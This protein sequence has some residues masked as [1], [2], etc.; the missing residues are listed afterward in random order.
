MSGGVF[1]VACC[2]AAPAIAQSSASFRLSEHTFNA[3]GNPTQGVAPSSV[4]FRI[5]L[6]A[7]GQTTPAR[8]LSSASFRS[9][10]GFLPAFAPPGE[11]EGVGFL[12]D[13]ATF[14]W[15]PD[16]SVGD[17]AVYRDGLA[18]LPGLAYGTCL[19][20]AIATASAADPSAPADGQGFFYLVTA[21]NRLREEGTKGFRSGGVERPNA[22]PCP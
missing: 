8:G 17:Y 9:D 21:R 7:I 5:S 3:G 14:T 4:S 13:D 12:A 15:A 18:T 16:P 20:S 19:Q 10:G 1:L 11:I 2:I 22:A 6:D